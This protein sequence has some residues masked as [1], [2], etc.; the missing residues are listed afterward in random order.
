MQATDH[1]GRTI[2]LI[3]TCQEDVVSL[4][5]G[6]LAAVGAT[7]MVA[8]LAPGVLLMRCQTPFAQIA[9]R[10][11]DA[12]PIFARH[13]CPAQ[14]GVPLSGD[15]SDLDLLSQA[16]SLLPSDASG[17]LSFSVQSRIYS[18]LDYKPFDV[19]TALAETIHASTGATLD[20]R[21]PQQV[22]SVVCAEAT[23]L[24]LSLVPGAP[25]QSRAVAFLGWSLAADNLSDWAGGMRRFAREEGQVS[26]AEFKLLEALEVFQ[27]HLPP[28]GVA[29]DLGA[30]PGGW[31]RV[32][33]QAGQY[34]TAVDPGELDARL[35]SDKG[36]RHLRMT[37]QNYLHG[38]PDQFDVIVNDM[39]M[40]ARES[41]RL[42]TAFARC[43]QPHGVIIMTLKL[44]EGDPR[45]LIDEAFAILRRAYTI[46]GARQLFHNRSEIT[47]LLRRQTRQVQPKKKHS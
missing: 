11:R 7:E 28:H 29:L 27:V 15:P 21:H 46:G 45:P 17:D 32:L 3:L 31:T 23:P 12:P 24:L 20:V 36:I 35:T 25:R 47:L 1:P 9:A 42:M 26:R 37:A 22:L 19:N 16:R 39:R 44:P 4:A 8:V 43:L 33:R 6:E 14:N 18:A 2:L 10:W 41:A 38:D 13:I 30:A 40:D 5:V 34:V